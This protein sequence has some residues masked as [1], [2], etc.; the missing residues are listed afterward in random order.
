MIEDI[1][2]YIKNPE[3]PENN[4][5]LG[6]L[7]ENI[8]QT[9][10]AVSYYLRTSERTNI[11]LL[12]YECLIRC[13]ICFDKQGS[14]NFTVK[15]LLQNALSLLP[16]R[17]E[18]Y[19]L[20][21]RFHEKESKD[22]H[23]NDCYTISSIGCTVSGYNIPPLRTDVDYPGS[24]G[25]LFQ[26]AVSAWWC[27]LCEESKDLF[28]ILYKEYKLNSTFRT[29]VINNLNFLKVNLEELETNNV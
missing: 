26:K 1:K 25:I 23:W 22:G 20:L 19:Y 8:G 21:A 24:Y 12:Q 10:S 5:Q 13:S 11:E 4:Y 29:A 27:G 2:K 6:R 14:R 16:N 9:A 15:G 3:N 7:Y 17:P 18:A 28:K